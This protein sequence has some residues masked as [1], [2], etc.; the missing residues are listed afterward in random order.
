MS[1]VQKITIKTHVVT[2]DD[3]VV[4][5][6]KKYV[7]PRL[8]EGD[9][10]LVTSKI[11]SVAQGRIRKFDDIKVGFWANLLWRYV[12]KPQ[13]GIGAIGLPEKMQAAIDMVGLPRI[14]FGA[15][16]AAICRPFGIRGVFYRIVGHGVVGMQRV[17]RR[18]ADDV[19]ATAVDRSVVG[20]DDSVIEV[21]RAT[22]GALVDG[23]GVAA[24]SSADFVDGIGGGYAAA[25]DCLVGGVA[26]VP[27]QRHGADLDTRPAG[28]AELRVHVTGRLA[29]GH[30][31]L[32]TVVLN[33]FD[34]RPAK[35][36][37]LG[38]FCCAEQC[39]HSDRAGGAWG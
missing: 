14:L 19:D 8:E 1:F 34:G 17:E 37:D 39:G 10:V 33:P 22:L 5:V 29:D 13:Y 30:L 23:T 25:I 35:Q 32:R 11:V 28:R 15:F 31:Q 26:I 2:T 24:R 12:S 16:V 20:D 18:E 9:L 6:V 4:E 7:T 3:D 38:V 21:A 36:P 27:R